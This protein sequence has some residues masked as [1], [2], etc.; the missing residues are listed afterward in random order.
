MNEPSVEETV[1][2]LKGPEEGLRGRTTAS[3][4]TDEALRAAAELSAKHINDR[5]LPD[6]AIDVLDEAGAR[7]P[8]APRGEAPPPHH[9]PATWSGWWPASPRSRSGPSP[10]DDQAARWQHLE[11]ELKKV[12]FGQDPAID[13][14]ASAIKLSPLRPGQRR[15]SPSAASSSPARPASARPSWPSSW[16][17]SWASSSCA[18]T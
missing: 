5:Q 12:I 10:A 1:K 2:I 15:R 9:R 17:A 7:R 18:S 13:A 8:D 3:S 6:K 4:Y 14:I 11:P 16:P